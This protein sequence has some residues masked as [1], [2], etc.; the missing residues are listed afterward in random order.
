MLKHVWIFFKNPAYQ[1]YHGAPWLY[2]KSIFL[3]LLKW[4]LILG[5]GLAVFTQLL[6]MAFG[7]DLGEHAT[8]KLFSENSFFTILLIMVVVA[9]VLEEMIF[10]GPLGFF[11]T[12]PY[13]PFAFYCSFVLFG[14][15]H[16]SNFEITP[17][18]LWI[19]P[20]LIAPQTLMGVF[21][22]YIRVRLGLPWAILLHASYNGILFLFVSIGEGL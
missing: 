22:G 18:V 11:K 6:A 2:K 14:L 5:I 7:I 19:S 3:G 21:L 1:A 9:P 12:S 16:L 8:D 13:F 10:R 4:N 20:L 17:A 15:I